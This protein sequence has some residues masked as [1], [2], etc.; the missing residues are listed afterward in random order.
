MG[1]ILVQ[2]VI[3]VASVAI[4]I[5][6]AWHYTRQE[7][8]TCVSDSTM[9]PIASLLGENRKIVDS[10]IKEAGVASES[11]ILETYL[12]D[13][14]KD[15]VPKYSA[16][17]Q[18]IDTLANN[19]TAILALLSTYATHART[20][21]FKAAVEQYRDYAISFRD[22]WQ[23]VFEIFMAGGSLPATG[24]EYPAQMTAALNAELSAY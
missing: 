1:R 18:S 8:R 6:G 20:P 16:M 23:S 17:K 5:G 13:I 21:A 22:R 12:E 10:L 3:V 11:E 24:P 4:A 19:N 2:G 14:R 9:Q 7:L 15:G